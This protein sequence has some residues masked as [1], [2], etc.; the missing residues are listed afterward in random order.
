[1]IFADPQASRVLTNFKQPEDDEHGD[2]N[3]LHNFQPISA[4]RAG[5]FCG[6]GRIGGNA[7]IN[8]YTAV[9]EDTEDGVDPDSQTK[10]KMCEKHRE[11]QSNERELSAN[12]ANQTV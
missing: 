4:D 8:E 12:G 11:V 1:M 9:L 6:C 2:R 5:V 10:N 3:S 7:F